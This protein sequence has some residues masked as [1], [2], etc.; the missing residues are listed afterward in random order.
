M[1]LSDLNII[2]ESVGGFDFLNDSVEES[3]VDHT[4]PGIVPVQEYKQQFQQRQQ[5]QTL[6]FNQRIEQDVQKAYEE[7]DEPEY[8]VRK[9]FIDKFNQ[10]HIRIE[11]TPSVCSVCGFDVAEKRHGRWGLVPVSERKTV[12]EALAEHKKVVHTLG[13]LHIVKKSQLPRQWLGSGNHL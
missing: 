6:S 12:V 8:I 1:K 3:L 10:K 4:N 9:I 2:E 5:E 11:L 7:A 13:D